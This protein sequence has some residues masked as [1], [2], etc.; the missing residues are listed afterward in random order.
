MSATI[1]GRILSVSII[2]KHFGWRFFTRP[3]HTEMFD[4]YWKRTSLFLPNLASALLSVLLLRSPLATAIAINALFDPTLKL[5]KM[6]S[7][8][9]AVFIGFDYFKLLNVQ[10]LFHSLSDLCQLVLF[11]TLNPIGHPDDRTVRF[12]SIWSF[13]NKQKEKDCEISSGLF[14]LLPVCLAAKL[15]KLNW[16]KNQIW[17]SESIYAFSGHQ[18]ALSA[19]DWPKIKLFFVK[20]QNAFWA[21]TFGFP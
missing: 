17:F 18:T 8:V 12:R 4:I 15:I 1:L 13:A 20:N 16:K 19:L 7:I 14:Q 2:C 11:D 9:L 6:L 10:A 3:E 5:M 21:F